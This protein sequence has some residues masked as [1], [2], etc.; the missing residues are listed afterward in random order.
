MTLLLLQSLHSASPPPAAFC[1]KPLFRWINN[2]H[3]NSLENSNR[4]FKIFHV[5]TAS[6]RSLSGLHSLFIHPHLLKCFYA[7]WGPSAATLQTLTC[8]QAEITSGPVSR[9]I[10]S[11]WVVVQ[12]NAERACFCFCQ[13]WTAQKRKLQ[14]FLQL[15]GENFMK[16]KEKW[17]WGE[18]LIAI[19]S[20]SPFLIFHVIRNIQ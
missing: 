17:I 2:R 12:Y 5:K 18:N 19:I 10:S 7:S 20:F 6:S 15:F 8:S 1:L 3:S 4:S 16:W 13:S 11:A 9:Q 14:L